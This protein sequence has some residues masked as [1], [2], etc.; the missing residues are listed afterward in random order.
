MPTL[1]WESIRDLHRAV[2]ACGL[3]G[4][5]DALLAGVD[6]ETRAHLPREETPSAQLLSDLTTLNQIQG[7]GAGAL[8]AWL[9]SAL[10]LSESRGESRVFQSALDELT[11]STAS[12]AKVQSGLR[13]P[14]RWTYYDEKWQAVVTASGMTT[15]ERDTIAY[16]LAEARR[17]ITTAEL[18]RLTGL[19]EIAVRAILRGLEQFLRTARDGSDMRYAIDDPSFREF[20]YWQDGVQAAG[21]A[22]AGSHST[23][24]DTVNVLLGDY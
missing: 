15:R 13:A 24:D 21:V 6:P 17:P 18:A 14:E 10:L 12:P 2:V 23:V 22:L 7:R 20:L 8:E 1:R 4:S 3:A 5:R 16:V 11:S 9:E 19:S